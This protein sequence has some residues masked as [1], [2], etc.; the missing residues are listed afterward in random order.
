[1][2][3]SDTSPECNDTSSNESLSEDNISVDLNIIT[4]Y[5]DKTS[6]TDHFNKNNNP[7]RSNKKPGNKP[8]LRKNPSWVWQYFRRRR[9]SRKWKTCGNCT[10]IVKSK[11]AP[12]GQREC[13]QLVKTQGLTGNFQT[14][15]NTHG[16]TKPTKPTITEM[17][18]HAARQNTRQKESINYTL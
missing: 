13:G 14:Y 12:N 3:N 5:S 7:N 17:F 16:I 9:P 15:L 1:M 2:S 8:K 6:D 4:D 10:V 11:K 18:H